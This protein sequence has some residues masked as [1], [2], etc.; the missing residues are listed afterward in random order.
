MEIFVDD[1]F[2]LSFDSYAEIRFSESGFRLAHFITNEAYLWF[3]QQL[4]S[5]RS[6]R[7]HGRKLDSDALHRLIETIDYPLKQRFIR[8]GHEL[9]KIPKYPYLGS[10]LDQAFLRASAGEDFLDILGDYSK[11][12]DLPDSVVDN[13]NFTTEFYEFLPR[14]C[15]DAFERVTSLSA[16]KALSEYHVSPEIRESE[17]K[18]LEIRPQV[19]Y[20][21]GTLAKKITVES[22]HIIMV[23]KYLPYPLDKFC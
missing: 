19:S 9:D 14:I 16:K 12:P 15:G 23:C 8:F 22:D 7:L 1:I 5:T 4:L 2:P 17:T 11:G 13:Y 18:E 6:A 3:M 21:G 10:N 20:C